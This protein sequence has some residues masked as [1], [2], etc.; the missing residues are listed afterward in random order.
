MI[1]S[2]STVSDCTTEVL[3][4]DALEPPIGLEFGVVEGFWD[5]LHSGAAGFIVPPGP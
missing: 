5:C 4:T 2:R 3:V 1:G